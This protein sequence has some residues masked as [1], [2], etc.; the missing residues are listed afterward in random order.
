MNI[1]YFKDRDSHCLEFTSEF[2]AHDWEAQEGIVIDL[3]D[4]GRVVGIEIEQIS[5]KTNLSQLRT[6]GFPGKV[7]VVAGNAH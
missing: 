4:Y 5:Q 1:A 3:S 6:G 7:H 2:P